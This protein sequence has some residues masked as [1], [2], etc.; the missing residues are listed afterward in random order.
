M[1]TNNE[2][3]ISV[4]QQEN[5]NSVQF[6]MS[7]V[8]VK[9]IPKVS[10]DSF[11][12]DEANWKLVNFIF[13]HSNSARRFTPGFSGSFD[14]TTLS[15]LKPQMVQGDL[16]ELQKIIIS[17]SSR[18]HLIVRRNEIEDASSFDFILSNNSSL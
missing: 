3:L 2:I 4:L 14:K 16:F 15:R 13:K 1:T 18:N 8:V 6:T 10:S 17:D 9:A 5:V 7:K 11:F 12:S